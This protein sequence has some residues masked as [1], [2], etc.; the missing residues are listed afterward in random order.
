MRR[1]LAAAFPKS[2]ELI[3]KS[4]YSLHLRIALPA[5][6]RAAF[7]RA[8]RTGAGRFVAARTDHLQV[9]KLDRCFALEHAAGHVL[10]RIRLGVLLHH[11]RA[12]DDGGAPRRLHAQ[13]LVL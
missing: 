11:V 12:L 13:D 9:R 10:L 3:A 7:I 8:V 2:S 5:V 4:S 6:P 1:A